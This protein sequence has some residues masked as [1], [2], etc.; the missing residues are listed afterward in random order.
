MKYD[1]IIF[2]GTRLTD[3]ADPATPAIHLD[4]LS[5]REVGALAEPVHRNGLFIFFIP[6]ETNG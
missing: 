2:K 4:G 3:Y 1:A 6:H 5:L